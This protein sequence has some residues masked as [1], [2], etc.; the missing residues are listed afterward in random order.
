MICAMHIDLDEIAAPRAFSSTVCVIG[1]GIAG[2]ILAT[3]LAKQGVDV[4]LLEAG[5]LVFEERSQ[6]FYRAEMSGTHHRGSNE[7]R[8]RTFGGSSIRWGG[9]IL[10]FASDI[11][12]P[13][14]GLPALEWPVK[15]RDISLYYQEIQEI[16]GV[17]A[18]P[19]SSELLSAIGCKPLPDSEDIVLRFSKRAPFKKR[20][21]AKTVGAEA[22]AHSKI[23][24]FTHANA[25]ELVASPANRRRIARVRVMNYARVEFSFVAD[26]LVVS[27]GTIESSRLL[28]CSRDVPNLHDQIGRYFHDHVAF[29]AARFISPARERALRRLGPF[30]VKGTIH[31][32]KFES[33]TALRR[34]EGLLHAVAYTVINEP[35]DSGA[36]AVRSLLRSLQGGRL[37]KGVLTS[38]P[39]MLRGTGDV[40][41]LLYY[42]QVL[43]RRA[44]GKR[45]TLSLEIDVEQAARA[46]NRIRV[47]ETKRDAF[48]LPTTI[49][50]WKI[51]DPEV[52]TAVRYAEILRAYLQKA[53]FDPGDW[54]PCLADGTRPVL[55]DTNHAM[56][57]L[58]MGTDARSSVVDRDL[59][60]HGLDNLYV[61]SCAVF[62]SGSSSN[63]TFTMMALTL[64]L[65]DHLARRMPRALQWEVGDAVKPLS[66]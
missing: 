46:E 52:L 19:F 53:G 54:N 58:R 64:R 16:M 15:E 44:V 4:S 17:D 11:F 41:R 30:Y 13:P 63:P 50:D 43:G 23:T 36:L 6:A 35:E 18:Y 25:L 10:P 42:S 60:F 51:N 49:V 34:R 14:P 48:G 57:G 62:P 3:R 29:H 59:A 7:G 5:G 61:A 1:G 22:I 37:K 45:A 65:A 2:L 31:T 66:R 28:L 56:G 12:D 47:S 27:A 21:L 33:S 24:V 32:C 20:N 26:F 39:P 8:F 38:L 55:D 9:Q 40:I